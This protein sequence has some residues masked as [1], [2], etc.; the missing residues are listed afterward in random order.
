MIADPSR[1]FPL[2]LPRMRLTSP[3]LLG[4]FTK[5]S[6]IMQL[7]SIDSGS[8]GPYKARESAPAAQGE[9]FALPPRLLALRIKYS[10]RYDQQAACQQF[11]GQPVEGL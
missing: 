4:C 7:A 10:F 2:W 6:A 3:H 1:G 8:I 5:K 9:R 11:L